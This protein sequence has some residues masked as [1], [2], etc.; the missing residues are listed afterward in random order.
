MI[1]AI[2]TD[3]GSNKITA[4]CDRYYTMWSESENA[5]GEGH[6]TGSISPILSP[7]SEFVDFEQCEL[8]ND[9]AFALQKGGFAHTL[10][11]L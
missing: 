1:S 6:N 11:L 10:Y 7:S 4:F 3:S 9:V 2:L 8:D 5:D